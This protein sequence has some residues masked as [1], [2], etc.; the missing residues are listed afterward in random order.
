MEKSEILK[1]S[2]WFKGSPGFNNPNLEITSWCLKWGCQT[3]SN[4]VA[5]NDDCN[6]DDNDTF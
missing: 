1:G 3:K 2:P 6:D 4:Y 5:D